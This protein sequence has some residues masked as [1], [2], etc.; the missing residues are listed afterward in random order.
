M[1]TA[2]LNST[3]LD[4]A[5]LVFPLKPTH[6]CQDW[7][8]PFAQ[9]NLHSFILTQLDDGSHLEFCHVG[10][11]YCHLGFRHLVI[12]SQIHSKTLS[13]L[14]LTQTN[15]IWLTWWWQ[16]SWI[17]PSWIQPFCTKLWLKLIQSDSNSFI[18]L[19]DSLKNTLTPLWLWLKIIQ[20]DSNSFILTQ[21]DDGSHLEFHHLGFSHLSFSSQTHSHLSR[22]VPM[23]E[24]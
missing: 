4:S 21:L 17:L 5:I 19:S 24:S 20:S 9:K 23:E 13:T 15:S 14:T 7:F 11:R 6:T 22:L 18:L 16:P 8:Q 12:F 1:V 10:F 2:I 3:I